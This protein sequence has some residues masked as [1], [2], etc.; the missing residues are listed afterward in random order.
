MEKRAPERSFP[1]KSLHHPIFPIPSSS[2]PGHCPMHT[3]PGCALP[4]R[5]PLHHAGAGAQ[6]LTCH[7]PHFPAPG[8]DVPASRGQASGH[9]MLL[10][11]AKA[12]TATSLIL[13]QPSS[14]SS[15]TDRV[16]TWQQ[17]SRTSRWR[18]DSRLTMVISS[19]NKAKKPSA[20]S[21]PLQE[22]RSRTLLAVKDFKERKPGLSP[23]TKNS[24]LTSCS[25]TDVSGP[26]QLKIFK[27]KFLSGLPKRA[28]ASRLTAYWQAFSF[29][30]LI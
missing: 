21:K 10:H 13:F 5:N 16:P 20:V 4:T 26:F 30:F 29:C 22:P 27:C 15:S 8:Q 1:L 2:V 11:L 23:A 28:I 9:S 17:G 19:G 18:R 14:P 25:F 12:E 24:F 7:S 6:P 3:P